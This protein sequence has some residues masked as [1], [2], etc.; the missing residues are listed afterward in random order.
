[1]IQS[2][3][4]S[5]SKTGPTFIWRGIFA[6]ILAA[7][8]FA[9]PGQ[10]AT[11]LAY[12]FGA[13]ILLNGFALLAA[14]FGFSSFRGPWLAL[15]IL[16]LLSIIA[17]IAMLAQPGV[18]ALTLAYTIAL[19]AIAA[20]VLEIFAAVQARDLISNTWLWAVAGIISIA[21]GVLIAYAPGR[22]LIALSYTVGVYAALAGIASIAFGARLRGLPGE[23]EQATASSR[24]GAES[25]R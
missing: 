2:V 20:G 7:I 12:A 3:A 15:E 11:V 24:I 18:G 25:T 5:V 16:G 10:T 13:Y 4:N 17:G 8:A 9:Y 22:G 14:G 19:W 23:I 21:A 6:L 1:M